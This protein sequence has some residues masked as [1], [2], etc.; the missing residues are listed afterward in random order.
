MFHTPCII[1]TNLRA[2]ALG[3]ERYCSSADLFFM[4]VREIGT[5]FG[6]VVCALFF[7]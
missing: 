1:D 4:F 6:K 7:G 2:T 3:H 5:T